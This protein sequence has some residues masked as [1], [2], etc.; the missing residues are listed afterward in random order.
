MNV[1]FCAVLSYRVSK[2]I[3]K[4]PVSDAVKGT[5][6]D[7][8]KSE[9]KVYLVSIKNVSWCLHDL[10]STRLLKFHITF[11]ISVFLNSYFHQVSAAY[12]PMK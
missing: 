4:P 2:Y 1:L 8:N 6:K 11:Y 5:Y 7:C 10:P 12:F 9:K 3:K